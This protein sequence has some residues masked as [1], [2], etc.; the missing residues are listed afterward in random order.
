MTSPLWPWRAL[1]QR[2]T[3]SCQECVWAVGFS[4]AQPCRQFSEQPLQD[5]YSKTSSYK[6]D[7]RHFFSLFFKKW[8]DKWLK[9][10]AKKDIG[11][12]VL[13]KVLG[14]WCLVNTKIKNLTISIHYFHTAYAVL[15]TEYRQFSFAVVVLNAYLIW[16]K[17]IK[18]LFLCFFHL[19]GY[20]L[21]KSRPN[22]WRLHAIALTKCC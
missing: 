2:K 16:E 8:H 15:S 12:C 6:M 9:V 11:G 19:N 22:T 10:I 18:H 13:S 17:H 5:T 14:L 4:P 3:R 7:R 21:G 1:L 20:F